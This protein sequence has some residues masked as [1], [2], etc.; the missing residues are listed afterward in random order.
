MKLFNYFD[1]K[2]D[3]PHSS[4]LKTKHWNN[5]R[6]QLKRCCAICGTTENLHIHHNTYDHL[7]YERKNELICLCKKHHFGLHNFTGKFKRSVGFRDLNKYKKLMG[8]E[9]N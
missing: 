8:G 7:W 9:V 2:R 4:Y 5:R 3:I 6:K 1:G